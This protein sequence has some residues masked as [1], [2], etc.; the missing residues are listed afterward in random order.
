MLLT[1]NI[2]N[3]NIRFGLFDNNINNMKCFKSWIIKSN[4]KKS[5]YKYIFLIKN[6]YIKHKISLQLIKNIV[7]GSVVPFLTNIFIKSL[8]KIHKIYP[9]IVNRY[10]I[11]SVYHNSN[12]LGVDLYA[13]AI[14]GY[15][16]YK[17]KNI[18]II[19]IGTALSFTC[20]GKKGFLKG[21][22]IAP[23]V[24]TS[25]L[26]LISNTSLLSNVKLKKPFNILGN[27]TETC[28]QSGIIYG[29][30]SMIEGLINKINKELNTNCFVI[31]TGGLSHIYSSLTKMIHFYDKL[32][33][34]RGLKF[35]FHFNK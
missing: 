13:N 5:L 8:Y 22:I 28:I 14:A 4:L 12:Q 19:D 35:L 21:I 7:I 33:T 16:L 6:T 2:G 29:Y 15:E 23:G 18:L 3:S 27:N 24:K 20:V 11:S 26:S 1:V 10:S 31:A 17:E 25:L 32:H 34:I 9:T 30:L